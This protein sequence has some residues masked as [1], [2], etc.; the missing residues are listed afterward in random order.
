MWG[1]RLSMKALMPSFWSVVAN[2][3]WKGAAFEADTLRE[4]RL[5]GA[6]DRECVAQQLRGG[7][8]T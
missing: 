2:T 6:G 1:G 3:A 8:H 7:H 4:G 5:G